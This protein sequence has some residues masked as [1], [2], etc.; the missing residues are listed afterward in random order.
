MFAVSMTFV[1]V[2]ECNVRIFVFVVRF[3]VNHGNTETEGVDRC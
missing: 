2:N 3:P 1:V